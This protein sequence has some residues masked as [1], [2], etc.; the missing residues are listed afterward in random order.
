MSYSFLPTVFSA[1]NAGVDVSATIKALNEIE[2][3]PFF[4]SSP[5]AFDGLVY[6]VL[7]AA[8]IVP[9]VKLLPQ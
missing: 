7:I 8:V 3:T 5:L 1:L 6:P 9:E 2:P 4:I